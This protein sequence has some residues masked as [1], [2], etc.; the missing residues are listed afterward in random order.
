MSGRRR[1]DDWAHSQTVSLGLDLQGGAHLLLAVDRDDL[2]EARLQ[3]LRET[4]SA[5]MRARDLDPGVDPDRRA[6][7]VGPS[8]DALTASMQG[9][10]GATA[11]PGSP[12]DFT[13][14]MSDGTLRLSL[15]EAGSTVRRRCRRQQLEVIRHRVDQVGVSE[16][17]IS[18]VGQDRILVQMPGVENPAQLREL[19]G[20]TAKMSFQMVAP[21]RARRLDAADA[22]RQRVD[23]GRGPRG[24][25]GRP[26]G[27]GGRGLRPRSPIAPW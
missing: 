4:L 19:L 11:Q 16:P 8:N 14:T 26:A 18:R 27:P 10:A 1:G 25:F 24:A 9:I 21:A 12:A 13:V 5:E 2:A 20:S 17:V 7:P 15:T 6:D 3:D 23:P 22:R